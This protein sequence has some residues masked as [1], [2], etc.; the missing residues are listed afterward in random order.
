MSDDW[1]Q[2]FQW[3]GKGPVD[4]SDLEKLH[5]IVQKA[6]AQGRKV[7]FWAMPDTAEVWQMLKTNQVDIIG[8]DHLEAL[9]VFLTKK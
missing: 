8:S 9:R 7:R 6:H 1:T 4:K 5:S 2:H 3:R